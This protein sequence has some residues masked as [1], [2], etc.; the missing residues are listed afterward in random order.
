MEGLGVDLGIVLGV[1]LAEYCHK[2]RKAEAADR[3][4][5]DLGTG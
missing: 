1:P 3:G 2:M 5:A 4:A